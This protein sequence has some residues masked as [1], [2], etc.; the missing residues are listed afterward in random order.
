MEE[1]PRRCRPRIYRK[2]TEV[3]TQIETFR[4]K[5]MTGPKGICGMLPAGAGQRKRGKRDTSGWDMTAPGGRQIS[6]DGNEGKKKA[7]RKSSWEMCYSSHRKKW[8]SPDSKRALLESYDLTNVRVGTQEAHG[9]GIPS[10][11]KLYYG[12]TKYERTQG[13]LPDTQMPYGDR[14]A[15]I[16]GWFGT[17]ISSILIFEWHLGT[18]CARETPPDRALL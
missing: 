6:P 10:N 14:L 5:H 18:D 7:L 8:I 17:T 13:A 3:L 2:S 1:R 11:R 4:A 9:L 15:I 12:E 16:A